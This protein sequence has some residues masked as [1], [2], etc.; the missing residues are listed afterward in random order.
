[1]GKFYIIFSEILFNTYLEF[2]YI[3]KVIVF[4]VFKKI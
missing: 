4:F 3:S 2:Y 1:M